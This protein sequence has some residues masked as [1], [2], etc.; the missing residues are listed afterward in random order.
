MSQEV[1]GHN[2]LLRDFSGYQCL[3]GVNR[4]TTSLDI[5]P[6]LPL[7]MLRFSLSN[8]DPHAKEAI[9]GALLHDGQHSNPSANKERLR[10]TTKPTTKPILR[11]RGLKWSP[12]IRPRHS[13]KLF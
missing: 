5:Q 12:R 7:R 9:G 8:L 2:L 3:Y 13:S 11:K 1:H 10:E 4:F 6:S